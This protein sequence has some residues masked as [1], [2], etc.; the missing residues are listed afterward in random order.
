MNQTQKI[1]VIAVVFVLAVGGFVYAAVD[2]FGDARQ[3]SEEA[4]TIKEE[5]ARL[6]TLNETRGRKE[7]QEV[8]IKSLFE[9]LAEI[10]PQ[11][12]APARFEIITDMQR[13]CEETGVKFVET[14]VQGQEQPAAAGGPPRPGAPPPPPP[15]PAGGPPGAPKGPAKPFGESFEPT[16]V[17]VR[18]IGTFES[19]HLFL[20]KMEGRKSY[21][22]VDEIILTPSSSSTFLQSPQLV[23]A[24][25]AAGFIPS[26]FGQGYVDA[27][28]KEPILAI[29]LN[30]KTFHY[31]VPATPAGAAPRPR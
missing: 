13:F 9:Q 16:D 10:L 28:K 15:G 17:R 3:A 8:A 5:L 18:L 23:A 7:G 25:Q 24:A 4:S 21:A 27:R 19:F 11:A 2:K 31:V 22:R 29:E 12:S 30:L 14:F 26:P 1:V 20:N 6:E